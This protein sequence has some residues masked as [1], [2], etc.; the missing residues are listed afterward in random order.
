VTVPDASRAAVAPSRLPPSRHLVR[1]AAE[2]RF[3]G[4]PEWGPA[5]AGFRRWAAVDE[6]GGAVHTGF[7]ICGLEPGGSLPAHVHSFEQSFFMLEGEAVLI[8]T[9]PSPRAGRTCRRPSRAGDTTGT[10]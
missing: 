10:R 3:A 2:A 5:A 1:R 9:A 6:G 7:G 8:T 4:P